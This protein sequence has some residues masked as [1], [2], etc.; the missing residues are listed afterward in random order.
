MGPKLLPSFSPNSVSFGVLIS[1]V[2]LE[3]GAVGFFV[4]T[5]AGAPATKN[6]AAP[7]ASRT[8]Q[9]RTQS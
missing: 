3:E 7:S 9:M 8:G 1:Q 4:A 6:P 2:K 5:G